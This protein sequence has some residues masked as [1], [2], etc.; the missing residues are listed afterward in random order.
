MGFSKAWN[1]LTVFLSYYFN[2]YINNTIGGKKIF[3][4]EAIE[5]LKF[6]KKNPQKMD[7]FPFPLGKIYQLQKFH[8]PTIMNLVS[9]LILE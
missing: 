9:R 7:W 6:Y 4:F 2:Y 3:F 5:S 8:V 1:F